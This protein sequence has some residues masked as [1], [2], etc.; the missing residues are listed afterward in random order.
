MYVDSGDV[1]RARVLEFLEKYGDRGVVVLRTALEISFDNSI[2]SRR[3]GDFSYQQ[4]V[5]RLRAMGI[6][7]NPANLLR[8]LEREYGVI[9]KTYD[10]SNQKWYRFVDIESTRQALDEYL[11]GSVE[12]EDPRVQYLRIKYKVLE[13]LKVLKTLRS[14]SSKKVLGRSDK[15]FFKEFVFTD[16]SRIIGLMEE[17]MEYHDAFTRELRVLNEILMLSTKI[18]EAMEGGGFKTGSFG[19]IGVDEK[20]LESRTM[21]KHKD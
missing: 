14:L 12:Q 5:M 4:L 8:I 3:L 6:N 1:V 11:G 13:P 10:S 15:R 18:A 9:E 20:I 2:A 17:M 16:L 19:A 7:Y 21:G